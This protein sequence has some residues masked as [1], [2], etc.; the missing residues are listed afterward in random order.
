MAESPEQDTNRS[1]QAGEEINPESLGDPS[2]GFTLDELRRVQMTR[3]RKPPKSPLE[4]GTRPLP[5]PSNRCRADLYRPE[6]LA[7]IGPLARQVLPTEED[8]WE[9]FTR[10]LMDTCKCQTDLEKVRAA[11]EWVGQ[12]DPARAGRDAE[13]R[14]KDSPL[15]ILARCRQE[16]LFSALFQ[17]IIAYADVDYELVR[18][19]KKGTSYR[20]GQRIEPN[21]DR[22]LWFAVLIDGEWR[23]V[24]AHWGCCHVSGENSGEWN[25]IQEDGGVQTST[26]TQ[27]T[28][29]YS[30]NE[31]YFLTDPWKMI[32]KHFPERPEW[33]LLPEPL[34]KDQFEQLPYLFP[35]LVE[36]FGLRLLSHKKSV[37]LVPH[38]GR[39]SIELEESGEIHEY[40]ALLYIHSSD[41]I[42][43]RQKQIKLARFLAVKRA[44]N[45]LQIEVY[46]PKPGK[47][48]L[49]LQGHSDGSP[50]AGGSAA[51]G[52][53]MDL[54]HYVLHCHRASDFVEPMPENQADEWGLG[55]RA[56]K[57]GVEAVSHP[58]AEIRLQDGE[59]TIQLRAKQDEL[60]YRCELR[61]Q[62]D[63]E[64]LADYEPLVWHQDGFD[65]VH[66]VAPGA[67]R[68]GLAIRARR[69][70]DKESQFEPVCDY[71]LESEVGADGSEDPL[72]PMRL[73]GS[74]ACPD[75][76]AAARLKAMNA[77]PEP[78][79]PY[80]RASEPEICLAWQH[81]PTERL[82]AELYKFDAGSASL[83][84]LPDGQLF[85]QGVDVGD[86]TEFRVRFA[87]N[88]CHLLRLFADADDSSRE[89]VYTYLIRSCARLDEPL[90]AFPTRG[91][92]WRAPACRLESG[93]LDGELAPGCAAPIRLR[94]GDLGEVNGENVG[95]F[96]GETPFQLDGDCWTGDLPA[97]A[98]G[99]RFELRCGGQ[100]LLSYRVLTEAELRR[101]EEAGGKEAEARNRR[102]DEQSE[103]REAE[104]QERQRQEEGRRK[105]A[106]EE[107]A[108]GGA[109]KQ[110]RPGSAASSKSSGGSKHDGGAAAEEKSSSSKSA[111]PVKKSGQSS[112]SKARE[113][114]FRSRSRSRSR[115]HSK[116]QSRSRSRSR[117]RSESSADET[118]RRSGKAVGGRKEAAGGGE[119][120][121]ERK[122]R[123][124][125]ERE[126]REL[127]KY[128]RGQLLDALRRKKMKPL[129]RAMDEW[130]ENKFSLNDDLFIFSKSYYRMME[131]RE[132]L[133]DSIREAKAKRDKEYIG[134]VLEE[135][136]NEFFM[137]EILTELDPDVRRALEVYRR[138]DRIDK[139]TIKPLNLDEK[140]KLELA[141]YS[142]PDKS[143]HIT[144]M[145][146]LLLMGYY[147]KRTRKW[148][149][150]QP[151]IRAL[152]VADFNRLDPASV[153][154]AIAAR[155]R[156][157]VSNLDVKEVALKS[158]AAAAFFDWSLN[159]V[160][161]VGDL[162]D[163]SDTKPA[164]IK[165]QKKLF[166]VS[167]E[168]DADLDW[169]DKGKRVQTA[170]ANSAGGRGRGRP[171]RR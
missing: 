8:T 147:E 28:V 106:A 37:A 167:A 134:K 112:P 32:F 135:I 51:A 150:C 125:E 1:G 144:C 22:G 47:Y 4:P 35:D 171:P 69:R 84:R 57:I 166:K 148:R 56:E 139:I 114:R 121:D 7:H 143:V 85:N 20:V 96:A 86:G 119:S 40:M 29:V 92:A 168:E 137:D 160:T 124:R 6:D 131:L 12:A 82:S 39:L 79:S 45:Q 88:G 9:S 163:D 129:K 101:R 138:F 94:V 109:K 81:R 58:D 49:V 155:A 16:K 136:N 127:R 115:S 126:K 46:P 27:G 123:K 151:L 3:G 108:G 170:N 64:P 89:L 59:Q 140:S 62:L 99:S 72:P 61:S 76:A 44:G 43:F 26:R 93:G 153:H 141:S 142:S 10:T 157:L 23:F 117:S 95:V 103:Q 67:G 73:I 25:R 15:D 52:Q 53:M 113:S 102:R 42:N 90:V 24:D 5:Y 105:E 65:L 133:K 164:S 38:S 41:T 169:E 98:E 111:S 110:H 83:R 152:K 78:K 159:A 71:L 161:A 120:R 80:I 132:K 77:R 130:E 50:A 66:V 149:R 63:T 33:Q 54:V 87:E 154:P 55:A 107:A 18:G 91:P 118:G 14:K 21:R 165:K 11:F 36:A 70:S 104:R 13:G 68:F 75:E 128:C 116:S 19:Y 156:E 34:T 146:V 17:R 74:L 31:T 97:E 158:A 48:L 162:N 30:C 100:A 60:E 2:V 122:A 145:S